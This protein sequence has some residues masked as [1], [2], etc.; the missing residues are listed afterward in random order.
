MATQGKKRYMELQMEELKSVHQDEVAENS[1]AKTE[2]KKNNKKNADIAKL[3]EDA[4]EYKEDLK[5]FEEELEIVNANEL[6]DI[7]SSLTQKFPDE[8]RDYAQELQTIIENGWAHFVETKKADSKEQLELIKDTEFGNV[9]ERLNV[10]YP[11]YKGDFETDIREFLVQRWENLINIKKEHIK[12]ELAEIKILGLKPNY[13]E[14]VYKQF[15]GI[16]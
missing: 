15:H 14:R 10:E 8:D 7:A 2:S 11:D 12:E 16:E 3:Y 4:A 13:V 9:V 1:S 5:G 6:K